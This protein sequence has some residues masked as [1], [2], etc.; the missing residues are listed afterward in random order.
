MRSE[1]GIVVLHDKDIVWG[2]FNCKTGSESQNYANERTRL[3]GGKQK[4]TLFCGK[5]SSDK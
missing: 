2:V 5:H 1:C 4:T 3:R